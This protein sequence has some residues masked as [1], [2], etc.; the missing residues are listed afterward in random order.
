MTESR[1]RVENHMPGGHEASG[2]RWNEAKKRHT[3]DDV[4]SLPVTSPD[5]GL[6]TTL[7]DFTKWIAIYRDNKHPRLSSTSLERM[8]FS[9]IPTDTYDWPEEGLHGNTSYGFGLTLSGELISHP[10]IIVGFTSHF[11]YDR[12]TDLLVVV[13]TNNKTTDAIKITPDLFKIHDLHE[14]TIF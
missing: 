4:V 12:Q 14:K 5:G 8:L 2:F 11:I 1:I 6:V 9:S 10:G 7:N 13:F 3:K